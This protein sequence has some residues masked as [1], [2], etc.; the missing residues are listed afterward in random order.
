MVRILNVEKD[1]Q[2][3]SGGFEQACP[4]LLVPPKKIVSLNVLIH[5]TPVSFSEIP[6]FP[7]K[8]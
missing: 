5:Y 6:S 3:L 7:T 8:Q 4:I 1:F 2:Y